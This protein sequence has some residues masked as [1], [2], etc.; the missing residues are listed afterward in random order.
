MR[1]RN[2]HL[3]GLLRIDDLAPRVRAIA[4]LSLALACPFAAFSQSP[5]PVWGTPANLFGDISGGINVSSP[6]IDGQGNA[7]VVMG[8]QTSYDGPTTVSIV[9]SQGTTGNWNAPQVIYTIP[10]SE[11]GQCYPVVADTAGNVTVFCS[12]YTPATELTAVIALR[13]SVT[14]GWLSPVTLYQGDQPWNVLAVTDANGDVV[15]VLAGVPFSSNMDAACY[16]FSA[17]AQQWLPPVGLA[18]VTDKGAALDYTL[19]VNRAGTAIFF[20]YLDQLGDTT[21]L[22]GQR[23][24][25]ATFTWEPAQLIPGSAGKNNRIPPA[26]NGPFPLA[27]D[28]SG[29]AS[30]F[31]N[32]LDG[33]EYDADVRVS[34]YENGSWGPATELVRSKNAYFELVYYG[35]ADAG[36]TETAAVAL[37]F[38]PSGL[39]TQYFFV[40]DGSNWTT[41]TMEQYQMTDSGPLIA[42]SFTGTGNASILAYSGANNES[43]SILNN[44][45]G[46]STPTPLPLGSD[47]VLATG[48]LGQTLLV[49]SGDNENDT[50]DFYG[51]WLQN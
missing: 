29:A 27:V 13:Y 46:W 2:T 47:G 38:S 45:T 9:K 28:S 48:S 14:A 32:L 19:S 37:G 42:F 25:I 8:L 35:A 51:S 1:L 31:F 3:S 4:M 50:I 20:V 30:I 49:S 43:L 15:L 44:G 16:V 10:S 39:I 17:A 26:G 24:D 36:A 33:S 6:A 34:R 18:P 5:P 12:V 23:F 22:Y 7:Y 11:S 40:Y 21:S 41:S